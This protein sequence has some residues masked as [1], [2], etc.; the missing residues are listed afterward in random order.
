MEL[1]KVW[2]GLL[3]GRDTSVVKR[4]SARAS[5]RRNIMR[6]RYLLTEDRDAHLKDRNV[7][8]Q[9]GQAGSQS[10][11]ARPEKTDLQIVR[12]CRT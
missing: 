3:T 12:T 2:E 5:Q 10:E 1:Q 8:A 9:E 7:A 6:K 11:T 4:Y